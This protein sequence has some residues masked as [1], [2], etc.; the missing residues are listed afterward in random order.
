MRLMELQ[1]PG[2]FRAE[3]DMLMPLAEAAS[4]F[5]KNPCVLFE[6][7]CNAGVPDIVFLELDRLAIASRRGTEPLTEPVDVRLMSAMGS[8]RAPTRRLWTLDEL[9]SS[10]G[11]SAAHLRRTVLPRLVD[12]GHIAVDGS[13]WVPT[14]RFRSL[15]RR[16]VTIEAKL[17]DWRGGVAQASRHTAVADAAWVAVDARTA[18]TAASHP[19]WF[20]MYGVGLV[21]VSSTGQVEPLITPALSSPRLPDRELLAERAASLHF[22]GKVSG[23]LPKVFGHTL[24][25][26]TGVDPRLVGVGAS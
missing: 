15:A 2:R 26:S 5:A 4:K 22:S 1:R 18:G 20:S 25:A 13:R 17:R 11:V 24:I 8:V 23:P 7:P 21:S 14:Y 9:S 6:V 3:A 19:E 16:I 10:A 12:C